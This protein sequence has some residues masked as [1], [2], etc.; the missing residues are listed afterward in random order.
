ME[1][2]ALIQNLVDPQDSQQLSRNPG[3]LTN[4]KEGC[5][6]H[7]DYDDNDAVAGPGSRSMNLTVFP[8]ARAANENVFTY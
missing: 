2:F 1:F 7:I 5:H 3:S 8:F 6:M 4:C